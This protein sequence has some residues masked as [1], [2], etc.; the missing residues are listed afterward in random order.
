MRVRLLTPVLILATASAAVASVTHVRHAAP[1]G[2]AE[3]VASVKKRVGITGVPVAGL[4]PGATRPLTVKV[5]NPYPFAITIGPL[6][7][8]VRSSNRPGCTGAATNLTVATAG[9]RGLPIGTRRSK[10]VVLHVTMPPTVSD[11]CQGAR[12]ALS[13]SAR[14]S[15]A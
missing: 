4:Y 14:A 13:F 15:R 9:S 7:A 5:T 11:A 1:P 3:I 6:T 8:R 10:T 2:G 12:F